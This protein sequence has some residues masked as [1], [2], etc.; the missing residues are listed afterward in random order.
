MYLNEEIL[1]QHPNLC[2]FMAHSLDARQDMAM[3]E[4]PKLGK[5]AAEKAIEEWG[6][7]KSTITHLIFCTSTGSE[8]PGADYRLTRLLDLN[9]SIK[10]IMLY[11]LGCYGGGEALRVAKDMAENNKGA[12]VLV[13]C[14]E[15]SSVGML[16]HPN[17]TNSNPIVANALFGDGAGACIV[18]S[19][20]INGCEKPLFELISASQTIIPNSECAIE[21]FISEVGIS[22]RI[23]RDIPELISSRAENILREVFQPL[24]IYDWN[25]IFWVVH[26]GGRAIFDQIE[27]KL[28]LDPERLNVSRHVLSEYGNPLGASIFFVLDEMRNYSAKNGFCTTGEGLE[29]G[30]LFAFGPGLTCETIVLHSIPN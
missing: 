28:A 29:W 13:V 30:V 17:N 15:I 5:D 23:L 24:G 2:S 25:S 22:L 1:K 6:Q 14:S 26:P 8:L 10:R 20:P 12:R 7:P 16:C 21:S 27:K 9:P 3:K 19:D 11:Q 18:G 4:V